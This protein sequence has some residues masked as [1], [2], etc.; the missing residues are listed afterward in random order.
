MRDEGELIREAARGGRA[1]FEA[2]VR[3]KRERVVRIANRVTGNWEDALDVSQAVF[4]RLWDRLSDFDERRTFDTW[5]YRITVNAAIDHLRAKQARPDAR[6]LPEDGPE[7]VATQERAPDEVIDL[8]RLR[9]AFASLAER[10]APQ[11]RIAFVLREIEGMET[12]EVARIMNVAPSTVRNHLLQA[13]RQLRAGLERDYPDL[14]P[15][16]ERGASRGDES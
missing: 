16:P 1:A 10:L 3:L 7:P 12:A 9:A 14:V 13:R 2:L 8:E 6:Q 4:L 15:G 11:Q 5:L